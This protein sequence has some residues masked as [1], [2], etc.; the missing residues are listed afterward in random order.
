MRK[1]SIL[2]FKLCYKI[3]MSGF[4]T[5]LEVVLNYSCV[6]YFINY[7]PFSKLKADYSL[8]YFDK[9]K[10]LFLW[11]QS[12]LYYRIKSGIPFLFE[13]VTNFTLNS[14][15]SGK[16]FFFFFVVVVEKKLRCSSLTRS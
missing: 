12:K 10:T 4:K 8:F 14:L 6:F 16:F 2:C 3:Y 5:Y 7:K 13:P 9:N 11:S 15:F 1:F